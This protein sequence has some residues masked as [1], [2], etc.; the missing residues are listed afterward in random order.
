[1]KSSLPEGVKV[2]AVSKLKPASDIKEAYDA[3]HRL[4]GEN[5]ATEMRDKHQELPADIEWHFIGHL[6]K[7]KIKYIIQY[8]SL[9]HGIDS[10]E[11][12]QAVNDHAARAGRVVDV[13]LQFHIAT[14]ATKFGMDMQEACEALDWVAAASR[15]EAGLHVRPVGVMG[16]ATNTPD[17]ELV[18]SEFRTLKGY[19]DTVKAT[20]FANDP[21]WKEVSMG[22]SAD[23]H[24]AVEEGS[25]MVR[26]G[27]AI[28]GPRDYSKK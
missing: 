28:F 27:S 2:V 18:R 22:M 23:Y 12:L 15:S 7:N 8:V 21:S 9:I 6:Q 20:R 10:L 3:G 11:L 25:T 16:M 19:F 1:M 17:R 5:Y 24:I 4:F 13:L 26:I 14:E